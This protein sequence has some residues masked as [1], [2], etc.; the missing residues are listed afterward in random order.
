MRCRKARPLPSTN[1]TAR[2]KW[3]NFSPK[4]TRE[5]DWKTDPNKPAVRAEYYKG[6]L[7]TKL[8]PKDQVLVQEALGNELLSAG[9]SEGAIR[10]L[11]QARTII[12]EQSV[13]ISAAG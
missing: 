13:A 7:N 2:K 9:D 11:E 1:H 4:S 8:T 12:Q 3:A 5:T 6:L 10:A